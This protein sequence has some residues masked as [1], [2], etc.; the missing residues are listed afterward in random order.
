MSSTVGS[1]IVATGESSCTLPFSI[2]ASE[3]A[4]TLEMNT[5]CLSPCLASRSADAPTMRGT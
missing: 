4:E 2:A 1:A 5:Y 3:Y